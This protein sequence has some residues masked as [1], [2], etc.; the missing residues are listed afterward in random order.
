[1]RFNRCSATLLS[2]ASWSSHRK[3]KHP[4][5]FFLVSPDILNCITAAGVVGFDEIL[6]ADHH[7]LFVNIDAVKFFRGVNVDVTHKKSRS[8]TTKNTKNTA[9]IRETIASEWERRNMSARIK[10]LTIVSKK[11]GNQIQRERLE[12]MWE[13]LDGEIGRIFHNAEKALRTPAKTHRKWS[14]ALAK[15]GAFKQYWRLR[16]QQAQDGYIG[17]IT[18]EAK[19]LQIRD[20][21]TNDIATLQARFDSA[22]RHFASMI[23]RDVQLRE[24]HLNTLQHQ[25]AIN[26]TAAIQAE[27]KAL[28]LIQKTEKT[29]RMFRKIRSTMRPSRQGSLSRVEI[30]REMAEELTKE[31]IGTTPITPPAGNLSKILQ[32]ITRHKCHVNKEWVTVIDQVTLEKSVL[33][34]CQE[35]FQQASSTP[36]GSGHLSNLLATSGLSEIGLQILQGTWKPPQGEAVYPE[37]QAVICHLAIPEALHNNTS[38][39]H[40][41]RVRRGYTEVGQ[42]NINISLRTPSWLLQS[43]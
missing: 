3:G 5:D 21:G 28:R 1:M 6:E 25:M 8:F 41:R 12:A 34:Y 39:N 20:D 19:A 7:P 17:I 38:Q 13:K 40:G 30:P 33:L 43:Y 35:H 11:A 37:L 32:R 42:T 23:H 15:A 14:P 29:Q 27:L 2:Q 9:I 36:F 18:R 31:D 10:C 16:L 26:P 4:I 24:D 22:T